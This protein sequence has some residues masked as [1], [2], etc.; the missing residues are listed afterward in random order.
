MT[1]GNWK[2][3]RAQVLGP[4]RAWQGERE[5]DLGGPRQR[6]AFAVL[7][8]H[9]N[10]VVSR[11]ELIDALWGQEPPASAASSV[12]TYVTGLRRVLEPG[13][14]R[15]SSG[16]VL[17]SAKTGYSLLLEDGALDLEVFHHH[18][19]QAHHC[20]NTGDLRGAAQSFDA[21]LALWQGSPLGAVSGSFAEIERT[22]LEE[23]RLAVYDERASVLLALGR[24]SELVADLSRLVREY[25]LREG[26]RSLLMLALYRSGRQAEAL[27]VFQTTR[28]LLVEELGIEPG[29]ELQRLNGQILAMDPTLDLDAPTAPIADQAAMRPAQRRLDRAARELATAVARQWTAEAVMRSLGRPEPIELSWSSTG[30]TAAL[31]ASAMVRR[32][33]GTE[34][35]EPLNL[36]GG[37]S[38][39]VAKFRE[40]PK[41]QLVVL[42]EPGAGK[43]ALA[44][45]MILGMLSNPEPREPVPVLLPLSS[46]D[47]RDEHLYTWLANKLIEEYPGLGNAAAYGPHAAQRLVADGHVMPVLDGLD[48]TPPEMQAAAI[49]AIDHAAAGG[50]P[51]VVTCRSAEYEAAVLRGG[52]ILAAATLV[53]IQPVDVE[54]AARF[55][56]AR[57]PAGDARWHSVIE[58]LRRHPNGPLAQVMSNPLMVDL[59]R[60][61]YSGPAAD[62]AKLS[63]AANFPDRASLEEHLLGAF[64]PAAYPRQLPRPAS[65]AEIHPPVLYQYEPEKARRWLTFLAQHLRR[66]RTRDIAW[67]QLADA[68]PW[69]TRGLIFGLP[70][71]VFFAITGDVAGGYTIGIAYGVA[72]ALAGF[73]TNSLGKR[74]GPLRV[75]LRFRGTGLRFLGRFA[76]GSV[77]AVGLGLGWSLSLGLVLVLV[78]VFGLGLGAQ[79]WLDAPA[80]ANRVSSPL[81]VL[82]Q[83]RVA[84]LLFTLSF[85][86]SLG[87]FYAVADTFTKQV[88][89]VPV[90]G[91]SFDVA[92][93]L[94]AGLAG[95]LLGR[96]AFGRPG[97]V[98]YGLAT[99]AVGGLVFPRA[100]SLSAG[101]LAG[102][103]FGIAVGLTIFLS[104]AWGSFILARVWFATRGQAPLGLMR[105]LADAHR[106]AVLRQIGAV[107]QFRHARLQ[108]NLA[109]WR[110]R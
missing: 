96:F 42:G 72:F 22:R 18:R 14:P 64:L 91:G 83:E 56:T 46:W 25:P 40:L 71:A 13:R 41:R 88:R 80:D 52:A 35:P 49:E 87:T 92:L 101:V 7:A 102:A 73:A 31:A 9:A 29:P 107:Y 15:R 2:P 39:L 54:D 53:E 4:V 110:D 104:R 95:A 19:D 21:A 65:A 61:A 85:L 55:L 109:N 32:K 1:G 77:I 79:V 89:F 34:E 27:A 24:H 36:R 63:A 82:K 60:T 17:T 50:R 86:L 10:R 47:P 30:L 108:D 99:A 98:A 48:E 43:T 97:S 75:E 62:P 68:I 20:R 33:P 67:W 81:M 5:L 3:L 78:L 57:Q 59:A 69:L 105:F 103:L 58:Y 76:I 51:L 106:R 70:P 6:A 16:D 37:L 11:T 100:A 74:S 45:L 23:L 94:A 84:S 90:L 66:A 38:D 26:L 93:A 44:V 12:Y 8:M 28:H